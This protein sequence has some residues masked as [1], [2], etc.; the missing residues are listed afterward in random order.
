MG[1]EMIN[2]ILRSSGGTF[3]NRADGVG[4]GVPVAQE[5]Q[6]ALRDTGTEPGRLCHFFSRPGGTPDASAD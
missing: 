5:L 2:G 4:R 3:R 1:S 6:P